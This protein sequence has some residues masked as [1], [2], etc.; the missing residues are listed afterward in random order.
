MN[1]ELV[2]EFHLKFRIPMSTDPKLLP[3]NLMEHR[4]EFMLEELAELKQ[5]ANEK[6]LPGVA[7]ALVDLAYVIL[8]TAAQMGLPWEELVEEVHKANMNKV[9][10]KG[11]DAHKLGILKPVGWKEPNIEGVINGTHNR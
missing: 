5:S 7:D 11:D 3:R 10:G 9:L 8:G 1:I 4:L 2:K 6:S